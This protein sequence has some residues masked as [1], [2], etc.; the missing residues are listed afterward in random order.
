MEAN[1][2]LRPQASHYVLADK[3]LVLQAMDATLDLPRVLVHLV[4][5]THG[6]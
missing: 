6:R 4:L 2:L 1:R 5:L 3:C